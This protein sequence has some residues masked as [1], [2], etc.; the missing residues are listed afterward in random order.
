V[1][2]NPSKTGEPA[3]RRF[4]RVL[5][6]AQAPLFKRG[7]GRLDLAEAIADARN[8]LTARVL[9]NRIW[10]QHFGRGLVATP[11]NFG[12]LGSRPTHPELL[13]ALA[14]R[15]VRENW[16][17]KRLHKALLLTAAY[18]RSATIDAANQAVDP[19]NQWLWRANRRRLSVEE[20]RDAVLAVTG[21][22]DRTLYGASGDVDDASYRRRTIYG[23]VSRHELSGL[24]RLFDFPD[25]NLSSERRIDTTLPQQALFLLNS[26]FMIERS[27][28]LA[29]LG[30]ADPARLH[31]LAFGRDPSPAELEVAAAYLSGVDQEPVKLTRAERY[32][33]ALLAGNAFLFID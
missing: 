23:R 19:E 10:Q 8:P 32:A 33:Q 27:K 30:A 11:S 29:A 7:S 22:L 28:A 20:L 24:L 26:P 6:G 14:D 12:A 3:P 31:A 5:A 9:V 15:F 17:I 21:S 18:Q 4:L 2:G 25:P 16:S 13:D 1:R